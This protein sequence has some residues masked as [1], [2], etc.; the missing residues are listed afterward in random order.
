MIKNKFK[1]V[2]TILIFSF[3]ATTNTFAAEENLLY[4]NGENSNIKPVIVNGSALLPLRDILGVFKCDNINWD[5]ETS[6]ITVVNSNMLIK[7]SIGKDIAQINFGFGQENEWALDQ[8]PIIIEGKTYLPLRFFS[9]VF[10]SEIKYENKKVY[11]NTPFKYFNNNWYKSKNFKWQEIAIDNASTKKYDDTIYCVLTTQRETLFVNP[12][13]L[14]ALNAQG[15]YNLLSFMP[16]LVSDH[17]ILNNTLYY[18]FN[19]SLIGGHDI[20]HKVNLDD[21]NKT[22]KLGRNDFTYGSKIVLKSKDQELIDFQRLPGNWETK[23]EGVY[24]VGFAN[25]AVTDGLIADL[26]LLKE[27]YGYYL[28]DEEGNHIL[29]KSLEIE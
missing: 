2:L 21:I 8:P 4:I 6:T 14:F 26:S 16:P 7:L 15:D 10:L 13:T 27:T 28:L 18:Q 19:T 3:F 25:E 5:Q 17:K 1:I 12:T 24:A 9:D 20:I 29:I 11:L 22:T 23:L